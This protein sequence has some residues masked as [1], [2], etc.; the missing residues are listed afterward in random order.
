MR[1]NYLLIVFI[2]L[3][4]PAAIFATHIV[5]GSITYDDLG[6]ATYRVT[7]KLYR[8]CRPGNA[9]FPGN[10]TISVRQPNG[11]VFSPSKDIVINFTSSSTVP[12]NIDTCAVNPGICLEEAI[13]T[14]IVNNLPPNPGGYHLYFSYCCRN[15]SLSNVQNPLSTGETWYTHIPDNSVVLQNSSPVWVKPPPV[16][17]CQGQNVN[18]NHS[19]TDAD[20]DSLVYSLYQP[21][22]QNAPT[23]PL[24]VATFTPITYQPNVPA[25]SAY[26]P[27]GAGPNTL[28]ITTNGIIVGVPP[29]IGQFV[30]GVRC[31]EYRNGQKLGEIVRDFQMNVIY[32]P[33]LAQ[34]YFYQASN[35]T[36]NVISFVDTSGTSN[37]YFW[38]FGTGNPA[39]T[40]HRRNPPA[41][42]YSG[43]GP[44]TVLLVINYGT[45]CADTAKHTFL[46]STLTSIY[47]FTNDSACVGVPIQFHDSSTVGSNA[48]IT[49]WAWNFGDSQTGNT[50]NPTHAYGASGT[51]TVTL[52]VTSSAGCTSTSSRPVYIKAPPVVEAG[53]DTIACTNNPTVGLSGSVL[54][55]SGG[56]WTGPG[57]FVPSNT[58]LN[59]TYTPTPAE[60]TAG[61]TNLILTSNAG[62]LC[63]A[64]TDTIKITFTTGP[65]VNAGGTKHVCKDSTNIPINGTVTIATGGSWVTLGSGTFGNAN[66]LNTT[67]TPSN[68]DTAAGS[69]KLV[70][71]TTGNGSCNPSHDTLTIIFAPT[72][73]VEALGPVQTCAGTRFTITSTSTTGHG[74]WSS[75]G[76]GS[77]TPS[78]TTLNGSYLPGSVDATNGYINLIF[79]TN[80]NGGCKAQKDTAHI[81]VIP[82]PVGAFTNSTVCAFLPTG[83]MDAST[84]VG[85]LTNWSW[86]FGDAGTSTSQ[87]P[88]HTYATGGTYTVMLIVTS[89]NGCVDTVRQPV[90]V[91][92]Q[93]NPGFTDLGF[94]LNDGTNFHDTSSVIGATIVGWSWNFGDSNSST[95]TS[96]IQN[97][98]HIFTSSGIHN[99]TL[100][101]ISSQ[102]CR[103]TITRPTSVLPSPFAHFIS[104][105]T[106]IGLNQP[107]NFTDQSTA[108]I[109]SWHWNFGDS[110]TSTVE[111]PSHGY[112][113]A[114]LHHVCLTVTDVNGCTDSICGDIIVMTPPLVPTG[115]TPNGDGTN[116]IFYV[117]GGPFSNM[118]MR[119][120]NNWGELIFESNNQ[121]NGW[122]GTRN[123]VP[124]PIGVYVWTLKAT[125]LD[126]KS[127][128]QKGD[129]TLLR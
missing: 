42:T 22:D 2:I 103:D 92:Y 127:H 55:A 104:D 3:F 88:Q 37:S 1:K 62:G 8:D 54:N 9:A 123:G 38:N 79:T 12:P 19:A 10:V 119:I 117:K 121:G 107:V 40:S 71:T 50:Q 86:N 7:L 106:I 15:S 29:N 108:N 61:F 36:G 109:V 91:N 110:T 101:A 99:V 83:F 115:F 56:S 64:R 72:P 51:Y 68:A 20:G 24:N 47:G 52:T 45:P 81:L 65:G 96:T 27:L 100:I 34:A 18:F 120:Y 85:T 63:A 87:N 35:C 114:G 57:S 60:V 77:F 75:S 74:I 73:V 13:Y 111:N 28:N 78:D 4:G 25:Y 5:G 102:G 58:V 126:G 105:N 125:T 39:D 14:K 95:N 69:V 112:N 30:V 16:F 21:Y 93:P 122:D 84:T 98:N 113:S 129:V 33:P 48:T 80:N 89:N 43:T 49:N 11:A 124:Q 31:E 97:P 53:N 26:G 128:T 70:L 17:V 82:A 76:N 44:Y 94:C 23:F 118:D 41:F 116:D 46:I 6:G 32:C 66:L 67:Y 90:S 59:P